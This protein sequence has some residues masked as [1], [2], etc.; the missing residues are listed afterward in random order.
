MWHENSLKKTIIR[1]QTTERL[2]LQHSRLTSRSGLHP[3]DSDDIA[4]PLSALLRKI[5]PSTA[6]G[7][8][9]T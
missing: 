6:D 2:V 7:A 5:R 4:E 9:V 8:A 3:G 1:A